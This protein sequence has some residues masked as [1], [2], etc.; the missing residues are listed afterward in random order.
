YNGI[1]FKDLVK[2]PDGC[3]DL[4]IRRLKDGIVTR[5]IIVDIPRMKNL[6]YLENGTAIYR[7]DVE[8]WE[9]YAGVKIGPGDAIFF[10]T[11]R[12]APRPTPGQSGFDSSFLPFLRE[13][14]VAMV[15]SESAHEVG[16]LPG[17]PDKQPADDDPLSA[18]VC[19]IPVHHFTMVAL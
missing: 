18:S 10:R 7:E 3:A 9:K 14:D 17:C 8:A 16:T 15:S 12:W 6:P 5:G 2:V 4:D 11:G 13:R 1:I 19:R